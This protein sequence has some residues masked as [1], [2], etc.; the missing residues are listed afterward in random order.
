MATTALLEATGGRWWGHLD[1]SRPA[2]QA[3][4]ELLLL[5]SLPAVA[6]VSELACRGGGTPYPF[7]PPGTLVTTGPYAYVA[8]PMQ[9]SMTLVLV[10]WG[11]ILGSWPVVGMA[12]VGAAFTSG[13]AGWH[14]TVELEQRFGDDWRHYRGHVH[15]WRPRWRPWSGHGGRPCSTSRQAA[16]PARASDDG[17]RPGRRWPWTSSRPPGRPG[18]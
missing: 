17:S 16:I 10:A 18:R 3:A 6:A 9:L 12:G 1:L 2:V 15:A 13:I 8:N 7:D 14:E 4:L 5:L 11:A